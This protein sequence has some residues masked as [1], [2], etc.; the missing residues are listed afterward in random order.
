MILEVK[1]LDELKLNLGNFG[2]YGNVAMSNA[3][4]KTGA[5]STTAS[6]K[7]VRTGPDAWRIKAS[8]LKKETAPKKS[9]ART[10]TYTFQM[11]SKSIPLIDFASKVPYLGLTTPT[12][13]KRHGGAGVRY[14]L[15]GKG[16]KKV[17]AKSFVME[18]LFN[19]HREE[20]FTRRLSPNGA[21]I[22]AQY[23]ITPSSM[24]QQ[25]GEDIF[26]KTFFEKFT[27]IYKNQLSWKKII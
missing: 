9:T 6:L 16:A 12:G 23:S 21:K 24:F 25:E 22:T 27:K 5:I 2:K 15:K 8:T 1:G 14:L 18:S 4:N 20:I 3:L 10:T 17:L 26:I 19:N 13:K 7:S 11:S